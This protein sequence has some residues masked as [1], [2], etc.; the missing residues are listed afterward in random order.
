MPSKLPQRA[1]PEDAERQINHGLT[2]LTFGAVNQ[3]RGLISNNSDQWKK[4]STMLARLAQSIEVSFEKQHLQRDLAIIENG[5]VLAMH[6]QEQNSGILVR[7]TSE[8]TT[9]DVFEVQAPNETVMSVPGKLVRHFP[10]RAVQIPNSVAGNPDFID[11]LASFLAQMNVDQLESAMAKTIKGGS[12][13]I[14]TR[15]VADPHYISQLFMGILRGFGKEIDP[16]R[17]VKRISDEVLWDH[18]YL[19]WRRSPVWLVIRVA[20]QTS[21]ISPSDYKH[22]MV[23]FHAY[24]LDLCSAQPSFS[25]DILANMQTKIARRLLKL[26]DSLPDIVL[27]ATKLVVDRTETL[28]QTRWSTIQTQV[29]HFG[30]LNLNLDDA[31]QQTLPNSRKYLCQVLKGLSDTN[32]APVFT[33]NHRPRLLDCHD[34]MEFANGGLT[35]SFHDHKIIALFD[36]ENSVHIHLQ[37]WTEKNLRTGLAAP[38]AIVLSCLEEYFNLASPC[39]SEDVADRSIMVLT[40]LELWVSLDQ[41][42]TFRYNIMLQYS[43]EIPENF[44]ECL[45]LR[46]SLHLDRAR[47]V[48]AYLRHRR[49]DGRL[50][51]VFNSTIDRNSLS[52]RVFNQ[53]PHMKAV[54]HMIED[55]GHKIRGQKLLE[56]Q[57]LNSKYNGLR[58]AIT[59]ISCA[60]RP[61]RWGNPQHIKD[62]TRCAMERE[63]SSIRI[64]V[65][66]WPLPADPL[67][68]QAVVFELQC[69]EELNIWRS[70]TY[71]IMCNLGN[72]TR[73][74]K[75]SPY[76]TL[77]DHEDFRPWNASSGHRLTLASL[78]KPF[79][80]SH[81]ATTR[82]PSGVA[83]VCVNNS[84]TFRLFDTTRSTWACG[85]FSNASVSKN[86]TF[87]LP[88]SSSYSHLQYTLEG[89]SHISNQ[90]LADQSDC[91]KDISLHEHYAFGTLRS[92]PRLQWMN[93][94]RGLEENILTFSR[95]EINMLHAQA[96]WQVGTLLRDDMTRDWHIEL[97]DPKFGLLLVRQAYRVLDRVQ[98]NWLEGITIYTTVIL[99]SRLLAS[100]SDEAAQTEARS[101][102]CRARK[103]TY[104]W[105]QIIT[106]HLQNAELESQILDYQQRVCEMAVICRSTYDVDEPHMLHL[107]SAPEDA[108]ALVSCSITLSENRPPKPEGYLQAMLCRDRRL[109]F[110]TLSVL[111]GNMKWGSPL[112]DASIAQHW[113]DYQ[114]GPCGWVALAAPNSQWVTTL[115]AKSSAGISQK[116]HLNLLDGSLL[117]NGRPIG[118][119]PHEYVRHPTYT[120]LFG[121][122]VL[123]V[124]PANSPGMTFTTRTQIEGNTVSFRL[125]M[126]T[127]NLVIQSQRAGAIYELV[128]HSK[129]E[130][131]FPFF[132]S[133]DYHHWMNTSTGIMEFR[134][135]CKPW[136]SSNEDWQ[137][138]FSECGGSTMEKI[139]SQRRILLFNI[140]SLAFKDVAYQISPI[141]S[142]RY[143]HV[144]HLPSNVQNIVAELP[145]M[146]LGFFVNESLQLESQNFP[147][148]VFDITQ[149]SGTMFGLC[150]QL[151]LCVKD[152][153]RK[154]LP[155][156][157]SVLIPYG[158][159]NFSSGAEHVKV[160]IDSGSE[161]HITFYRY[162]VD[163]ELGFLNNVN[164]SLTG[165]L[166]KLYLHALTSYCRPDPLTGRTGTEEALHELTGS[167]TMSFEQIDLEQARLLK[168]IGA[169]TPH[170]TYYP[171]HLKVMETTTWMD[172]PSLSQ[173]YLFNTAVELVFERA[174]SLE[175]FNPLD[176]DIEEY[177][178]K[179]DK[180]LFQ[181]AAYR[182]RM[183]Y[184]ADE[185][186]R[187]LF[188]VINS[189][190]TD[191]LYEGRDLTSEGWTQSGNIAAWTTNLVFKRWG[192]PTFIAYDLAARLEKWG[193]IAGP[194]HDLRLSY[195]SDWLNLDLA[196]SWISLYNLCRRATNQ[197]RFMFCLSAA[198]YSEILPMDMVPV[199]IS[200]A[201]NE[202]F[203]SL[204]PPDYPGY[205][206]LD[207]YEPAGKK[208]SGYLSNAT[209]GIEASP[210]KQIPRQQGESLLAWGQ[211]REAHYKATV[212]SLKS[213][214]T[215]YWLNCWPEPPSM[216]AEGAYSSWFEV[217]KCLH[218]TRYYFDSCARNSELLAHLRD[219]EAVLA[220]DSQS[221]DLQY[222]GMPPASPIPTLAAPPAKK[223]ARLPDLV[224]L[225]GRHDYR[226]PQDIQCPHTILISTTQGPSP[227][228]S[229]LKTLLAEFSSNSNDP[230]KYR[231]GSDL[232]KSCT[233]LSNAAPPTFP[234]R[235]PLLEC[236]ESN[237]DT[238]KKHFKKSLRGIQ[239]WLGPYN[240]LEN[241]VQASG[242]WPRL[243]MNTIL[244]QLTLQ[245]RTG[246]QAHNQAALKALARAYV[247]YQRSQRLINFALEQRSEDFYQEISSS[248]EVSDPETEHPDWLLAQIDSNFGIRTIQTQVACE[249][250]TPSSGSNTV[251]QLNMGEGKSSVIVPIVAATL[252]DTTRLVRVIVLKPLWRQ[253]F[254]LLVSRLSGLMNRRI[255]YLPFGRHIRVNQPLAKKIQEILIECMR[256]G[257]VLLVQP[258]HILSF[259]LMGIDHL[260]SASNQDELAA[261]ASLRSTQKWLNDTARDILD[262]SDEILH[263]RYQLVYTVGEQQPLQGHPDRWTTTQQVLYLVAGHIKRLKQTHPEKLQ[264]EMKVKG[265][266][267]FIRIMPESKDII[268]EIN[269]SV[270]RDAIAGLIPN[271]NF[272]LLP[273]TTKEAAR[274]FITDPGIPEDK[275][276]AIRGLDSSLREGLLLLR[277]LLACGIIEFTLK[278]K[279]YRVD[280][281]L[282][283]SRSLLAVP[284]R[285]KDIPSVRAE[286]GHPDVSVVLTCLSYYYHGL[287]SGQLDTCFELLYKLDSPATEYQRWTSHNNDI[288]PD[289]RELSGV[290]IKDREQFTKVLV[291]TFA[292]NVGVVDFFLSSV[293]FPKE[294]KQFTHKLSASGW[295]LAEAR[296]YL[297]TGFSGTNDNRYLLP[298]SI[299]QLDPVKQ[300]ATNALVLTYLLRP[301]NNHYFRIQNEVGETCSTKEFLEMLV[302]QEPEIRVLLDVGAQMLD[303]RNDELVKYWLCL[304]PDV[305][306][307]VYFNDEHELVILPQNGS[308]TP[309]HSSPYSQQM[310]QCIVYLDDG[311]T[312]GTDLALPHGTRAAVTLGPKTTKDRLIQ[313]CMRM[314]RLG[315]DQSV[316]F[317]APAEI[318]AQIRK[319]G[320][321]TQRSRIDALDI[322]RWSMLETCR[323]LN[324]Y[325]SYW[326]QQGAEYSRRA[327]AQLEYTETN[328]IEALK[329][330]WV[331]P[332]AR[333]LEEMYDVS[334]S[335]TRSSELFTCSAFEIPSL[336]QRLQIL[337]VLTLEDP[338]MDEEQEREVSHEIERERQIER[339]PKSQP[340]L[341]TLH[342]DVKRYIQQGILPSTGSGIVSLFRPLTSYGILKPN[343]WSPRLL[344]SLDLYRTIN[345]MD[346]TGP[347][348]Y[349]RPLNW[350]VSGPNGTLLA[351]SP[352]EVNYLLPD[353]RRSAFVRLHVFA[354]RVTRAMLSFSD[355]RFYSV[356]SEHSLP[357]PS[358]DWILRVQIGIFS[359]QLYFDNYAQ[360]RTA[361][362]F[363]GVFVAA[364]VDGETE[365]IHIQSDGFIPKEDRQKLLKYVPE[366]SSCDFT[367]SPVGM[368][369]DF[370]GYRRKGM[371]FLRTHMGQLLHGRQLTPNDF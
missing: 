289:L 356:P 358:V 62:C 306:A 336:S 171:P 283:L 365:D 331:A 121:Q 144:T 94:I 76:C 204:A 232:Q 370:V 9:F 226:S 192:N 247:E 51:S 354:P 245:A 54:K 89:T 297:T 243:T 174:R 222:L 161:R 178:T 45:L 52:T 32:K 337:G 240:E 104:R 288:T 149:S 228:I 323:D 157:K 160:S 215:E 275:V 100:T 223:L 261:S 360:Y 106:T 118:R 182:G 79:R 277:G 239:G 87:V 93:I 300:S 311:H 250:I 176:F 91:P 7:K 210:S 340:A 349:M 355:L 12:K 316:M 17:V 113:R 128:P 129:I 37:A 97:N 84:L 14:E 159:I 27:K 127:R 248:H 317:C 177:I 147:G 189:M 31:I 313:G 348:E 126:K 276:E 39:Y 153:I 58:N 136:S 20:L 345:A 16:R 369:K 154:E 320:G 216:P 295:D 44:V 140:H 362:G 249:M 166:F 304:R 179:H 294:A 201:V 117:V 114:P 1:P 74:E 170:R 359:G 111:N 103:V 290:N 120:R 28:L 334:S 98:G 49:A 350:I 207:K 119:L 220:S 4:M 271:L 85:P 225:M 257:G 194:S 328:N 146:K 3:Y 314:R 265:Q 81:Y 43:P 206:L 141:E 42:V 122:K 150:N 321:L 163:T 236:L 196:T 325:L 273:R 209:K 282:D 221:P 231:Y 181:R 364:E 183:R 95:V 164:V 40:I 262:E 202:P 108:V 200:F 195:S 92:G 137:L 363:L 66:E 214:L 254:H 133:T 134:P 211:R 185:A 23:F 80:L 35:R 61:D 34:F 18:A 274:H 82:I 53:S 368:L 319:A 309:F 131:D 63:A 15:E 292:S 252:A 308:P 199:L 190:E 64:S 259:K 217:Q 116:V 253:M 287:T 255:Y 142:S 315:Y 135:L 279:H 33:P 278:E 347:N 151:V 30:P 41:L 125:D 224:Q 284:Y 296:T 286:F 47:T 302:K 67:H 333:S 301:E 256:E 86:G 99:V 50:G 73:D 24:V 56:L 152:P 291:P 343:L 233:E 59:Q 238:H 305:A 203:R 48:H 69:P 267:P 25:S 29:P 186:S 285:A 78:T 322:I 251:L 123:D 327:N 68:A 36:F 71:K 102:L 115:T 175:L 208:I 244:G 130:N 260:L 234:E 371:E 227:I 83:A 346:T 132:F 230:L 143:I 55:V 155:Q 263:V 188:A 339:P 172:L 139:S 212:S 366:Y 237:R 138:R 57:T 361:C 72:A 266:F 351:L 5:D 218:Q 168:L 344:A 162:K 60:Y 229:R 298:T 338:S 158:N 312:R 173:H 101:F 352:N 268:A 184:P 341:C 124:V 88:S 242:L 197:Y 46:S 235:L 219:I 148:E 246:I 165:R 11:E 70:A 21:I 109:S 96:A 13:V 38:C 167:A 280:Y 329:R 205:Q 324:H 258:E 110:R 241:M 105:L 8:G 22:F 332:E 367:S 2:L 318:D 10:G 326:A 107:L 299:T 193:V 270:A 293:V 77:A 187:A 342:P 330:G 213:Q 180:I 307:A 353:I 6:I 191:S 65:H 112:F 303:L 169:L 310:D 357:L 264:Y 156:S 272:S 90:V 145:R 75:I 335:N 198:A 269:H 19:P 281:G 26:Q